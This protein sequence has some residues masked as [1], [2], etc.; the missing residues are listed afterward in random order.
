LKTSL[1]IFTRNEL[2]GLRT[3]FPRIPFEF[4]HEVIA[5]DANSTDGTVQYLQGKDIRVISQR[6]PGRGNAMI[7]GVAQT[8]GDYVVFLSSDG[9]EDPADIPRLIEKLK[10]NDIAVASR[11]MS[12]GHSDDSDDPLLIR[13]FGNRF[14]TFLVNIL[15]GAGVTDSTNG[16]RAIRRP[17]WDE[18]SIDSPYHEAEFQMTIRAAKLGMKIEEIP[19]VEGLRVGGVR[20]AS[21][22]KMAWTFTRFLLREIWIG[23]R[24]LTRSADWKSS[25]RSHYDRIAPVYEQRKREFYLRRIRESI[26]QPEAHRIADLGCGTGLVL[27]WLDGDKVGV[28]LSGGAAAFSTQR[29]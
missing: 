6:N 7:E 18:L 11:F 29:P 22:T 9:N 21:T 14:F 17:A 5:I 27:S 4:L 16:L 24:F 8:T 23:N 25:V 13:R 2:E 12:G 28:D 19:T 26:G 20:Y 10:D 3:V 15:W 1:I